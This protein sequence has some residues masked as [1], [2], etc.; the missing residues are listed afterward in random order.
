MEKARAAMESDSI[1]VEHAFYVV[2]RGG[3]SLFDA[4][5]IIADAVQAKVTDKAYVG[6]KEW[7]QRRGLQTT[8]KN[9][10]AGGL[11][12]EEHCHILARAWAHRMQHFFDVECGS[13][14]G[15]DFEYSAEHGRHYVEPREFTEI[16]NDAPK[17]LKERVELVRMIPQRQR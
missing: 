15:H 10:F 11:Y 16:A 13:A 6:A 5:G 14:E 2:I 17:R 8:F 7:C 3:K 9:T 12:T 1:C 4:K